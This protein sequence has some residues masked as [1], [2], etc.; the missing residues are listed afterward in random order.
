MQSPKKIRSSKDISVTANVK[1]YEALVLSVLLYNAETWSIKQEPKQR[2]LV[3]EMACLR[4]IAGDSRREHQRNTDIRK[5]LG[6]QGE[7]IH[8]IQK[9]RL[10]YFGHIVRMSPDRY[11]QIALYARVR[12]RRHLAPRG[13]GGLIT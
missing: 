13:H 12:G 1:V 10:Q 6:V 8:K 2:L 11:P 3:F 4:R 7:V 5:G 9:R